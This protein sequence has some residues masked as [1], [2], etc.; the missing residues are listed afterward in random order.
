MLKGS[1]LL[2]PS[3]PTSVTLNHRCRPPLLALHQYLL[4]QLQPQQSTPYHSTP[5]CGS[6]RSRRRCLGSINTTV[7]AAT[8]SSLPLISHPHRSYIRPSNPSTRNGKKKIMGFCTSTPSTTTTTTASAQQ[9]EKDN[10]DKIKEAANTLDIRVGKILIA[11]KHPEADSLFVEE[12]DVG[13]PQPRIIC[14]GLVDYIPINDL[15]VI[16]MAPTPCFFSFSFI[17]P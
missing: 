16:P 10:D 4:L 9:D 11:Y 5:N 17:F 15:M 12:V 13:E 8:P 7:A 1:I 6:S 3:S 2:S 14:S